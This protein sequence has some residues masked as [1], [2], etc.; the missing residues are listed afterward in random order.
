MHIYV[1]VTKKYSKANGGFSVQWLQTFKKRYKIHI[2]F[3]TLQQGQ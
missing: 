1:T 3:A 2:M